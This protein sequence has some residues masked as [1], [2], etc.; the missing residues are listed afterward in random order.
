MNGFIVHSND[1]KFMPIH[2]WLMFGANAIVKLFIRLF[3]RE[4]VVFTIIKY[5]C[6]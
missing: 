1:F 3:F 4:A 6:T 2:L 5:Y